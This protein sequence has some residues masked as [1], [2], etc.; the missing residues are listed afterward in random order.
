[1]TLVIRHLLSSGHWSFFSTVA[2][3][4]RCG[5][6]VANKDF[7]VVLVNDPAYLRHA[8]SPYSTSKA[9]TLP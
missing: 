8:A 5:V 1:M 7:L 9:S 2:S 3:V 4:L 6:V